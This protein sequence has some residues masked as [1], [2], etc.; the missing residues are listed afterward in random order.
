MPWVNFILIWNT[1]A[2]QISSGSSGNHEHISKAP[3]PPILWW[4]QTTQ[5]IQSNKSMQQLLFG[6]WLPR[7]VEA[8]IS[9]QIFASH[10]ENINR[11]NNTLPQTYLFPPHGMSTLSQ[12]NNHFKLQD[13]KSLNA[14]H[15][16]SSDTGVSLTF[17][18]LS[19]GIL[20]RP[21]S[22]Q[23]LQVARQNSKAS[24]WE[25]SRRPRAHYDLTVLKCF[26]ANHI[27][28]SGLWFT[29]DI[30]MSSFTTQYDNCQA[31]N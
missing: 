11:F 7:C 29:G 6:E 28:I 21:R 4:Q 26:L 1:N 3:K 13:N 18:W 20:A 12:R 10:W 5:L 19:C 31:A 9:D 17:E 14:K 16:A 30:S 23:T 22:H 15:S 2:Y 27:V 8:C 25:R 24:G